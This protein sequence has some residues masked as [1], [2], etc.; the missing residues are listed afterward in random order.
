MMERAIVSSEIS[1]SLITTVKTVGWGVAL[2]MMEG[3]AGK[4]SP[5]AA[6]VTHAWNA[7]GCWRGGANEKRTKEKRAS[8]FA[9]VAARQSGGTQ[10]KNETSIIPPKKVTPSPKRLSDSFN[11]WAAGGAERAYIT[12]I[13]V[14]HTISAQAVTGCNQELLDGEVGAVVSSGCRKKGFQ[15]CYSGW[16]FHRKLCCRVFLIHFSRQ[17]TPTQPTLWWSEC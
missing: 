15:S 1:I 4:A 17:R 9:R 8:A 2:R 12:L 7:R 13:L 6:E 3:R 10:P 11:W 14:E 16:G 5:D